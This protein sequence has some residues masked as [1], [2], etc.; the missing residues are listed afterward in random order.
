MAKLIKV[1]NKN[2]VQY[3]AFLVFGKKISPAEDQLLQKLLSQGGNIHFTSETSK[4]IRDSLAMN[5]NTF[6]VSLS[7]L[8]SKRFIQR[9]NGYLV[10]HPVFTDLSTDWVVRFES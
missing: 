1:K 2:R 7:R 8:T 3:L 5:E 9:E 4:A 6:S 10:C